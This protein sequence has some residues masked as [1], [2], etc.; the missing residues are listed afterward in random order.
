MSNRKRFRPWM[1]TKQV[2]VL[3]GALHKLKCERRME[4]WGENLEISC[5]ASSFYSLISHR[6]KNTELQ[7][8]VTFHKIS[9]FFCCRLLNVF[10]LSYIAQMEKR[11][12]PLSE[13]HRRRYLH[14]YL[15]FISYHYNSYILKSPLSRKSSES[16]WAC[17]LFTSTLIYI[18]TVIHNQ[19]RLW[20]SRRKDQEGPT[21]NL[22]YVDP[23]PASQWEESGVL[24]KWGASLPLAVFFFL[25]SFCQV[26]NELI[27][28]VVCSGG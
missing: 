14:V 16:V 4:V 6:R 7:L 2:Q 17:W 15:L 13:Q 24:I 3:H 5:A 11:R 18:H 12:R 8:R 22:T 10:F 27:F 25:V 19:E 28:L 1:W 21:V 20:S 23:R 9:W 26:K